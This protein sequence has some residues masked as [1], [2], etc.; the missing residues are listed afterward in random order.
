MTLK[1]Y[2]RWL[3]YVLIQ[4]INV[5]FNNCLKHISAYQEIHKRNFIKRSS[6]NQD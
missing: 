5:Q 3:R 1:V 6:Y 4:D 2:R